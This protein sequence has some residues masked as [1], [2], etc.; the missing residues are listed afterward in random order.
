MEAASIRSG[1]QA[2]KAL[3]LLNGGACIALLG[4]LAGTFEKVGLTAQ[5]YWPYLPR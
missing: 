3:L 1:N 4:F 2:L 5:N